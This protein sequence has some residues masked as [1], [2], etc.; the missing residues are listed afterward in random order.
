MIIVGILDD[1]E[2][3]NEIKFISKVSIVAKRIQDI[4]CR[5]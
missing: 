2:Q 1:E 3:V 5:D 4:A